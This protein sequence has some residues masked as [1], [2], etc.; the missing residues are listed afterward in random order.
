[1]STG[2][3]EGEWSMLDMEG[4]MLDRY[5]KVV[6]TI[7]AFSLLAIAIERGTPEARAQAPAG[8]G[9][10]YDNPCYIAGTTMFAGH[11]ATYASQTGAVEV[12]VTQ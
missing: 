12:H 8:C 3:G 9:A 2:C 1:M 10:S 5:T 6:L 11:P 7:I 4:P